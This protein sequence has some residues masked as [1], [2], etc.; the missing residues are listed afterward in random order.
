MEINRKFESRFIIIVLLLLLSDLVNGQQPNVVLIMADDMGFECIGANGGVEYSTPNID[1]IAEEGIR[2]TQC[3]S[4]PLCTPSRVKIMTGKYNFRN[5]EYFGYLNE[6]EKSFGTLMQEAEYKTCIVGK[7]QLNGHSFELPGHD[8]PKRPFKLGFDEFSLWQVTNAKG[9]RY[10]NPYI[11]TNGDARFHGMDVYGP[12]VFTDYA[13]DFIKRNKEHP[14]FLY[15]PM[16][17][18]HSPFVPTP[19]SQ[20]WKKPGAR[21]TQDTAFFSDMVSYTDKIVGQIK[22][23]LKE[24]GIYNNTIFIF[25]ADNG[26]HT[27]IL[28][29]TEDRMVKGAKGNTIIDGIHVP[30][31]VSW[32]DK[33]IKGREENEI[34]SFADFYP[35]LS[36]LVNVYEPTDGESFLPI[37]TNKKRDKPVEEILIYYDPMWNP[38]VNKYRG[39]FAQN[40]EY[41]LYHTGQLFKV[42]DDVLEENPLDLSKLS[43]VERRIYLQLKNKLKLVPDW[44]PQGGQRPEAGKFKK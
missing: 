40:S 11:N 22:Q 18:V 14:F 8:D 31:I 32:P 9:G 37:L 38:R 28:T 23:A 25:T 13:I 24:E 4:Q 10:A 15:Y 21:M 20:E 33:I 17:L 5:Y 34:I 36:E 30:L 7:W 12:D 42:N 3:Y 35:T 29:K 1:K 39:Y 44:D 19:D 41:K 6:D 16:V 27:S 43:L 2:F 26:T